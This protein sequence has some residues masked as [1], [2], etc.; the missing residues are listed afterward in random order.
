[1]QELEKPPAANAVIGVA[2]DPGRT[3]PH[4][5]NNPLRHLIAIGNE[6][7]RRW[8]HAQAAGNGGMSV[9]HPKPCTSERS[10]SRREPEHACLPSTLN[11][12]MSSSTVSSHQPRLFCLITPGR[13]AG[14]A[15]CSNH[16]GASIAG[17]TYVNLN[18]LGCERIIGAGRPRTNYFLR[19]AT[20]RSDRPGFRR[21]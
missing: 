2:Y 19:A 1:P 21:V 6:S 9:I 11:F 17:K 12:R 3:S 15:D 16:F 20:G 13:P 8:R 4:P 10:R 7:T 14:S 5:R 18:D